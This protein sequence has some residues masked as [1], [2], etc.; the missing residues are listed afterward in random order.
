M[1]NTA[2]DKWTRTVDLPNLT[3]RHYISPDVLSNDSTR[4]KI[5]QWLLSESLVTENEL[6]HLRSRLLTVNEYEMIKDTPRDYWP[7]VFAK[8]LSESKYDAL[9]KYVPH[10]QDNFALTQ[11]NRVQGVWYCVGEKVFAANHGGQLPDIVEQ[12]QLLRQ[13]YTEFR[14]FWVLKTFALGQKTDYA[15][16]SDVFAWHTARVEP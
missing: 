15:W 5:E 10:D 11:Y 1:A 12:C 8:G 16:A 14:P 6:A 13:I 9:G 7:V 2:I 3:V 4:D